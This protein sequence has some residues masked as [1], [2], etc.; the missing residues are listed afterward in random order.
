M[1]KL[2]LTLVCVLASIISIPLDTD[3]DNPMTVKVSPPLLLQEEELYFLS[4]KRTRENSM[5]GMLKFAL[6]NGQLL[7]D[8]LKDKSFTN[9]L[10]LAIY[11]KSVQ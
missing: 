6:S 2:K 10:Q 9:S 11:K 5:K 3:N 4:S 7:D 1:L 8:L